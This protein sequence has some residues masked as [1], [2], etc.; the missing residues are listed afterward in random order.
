MRGTV[1][2]IMRKAAILTAHD[3]NYFDKKEYKRIKKLYRSFN[4][5]QNPKLPKK[6]RWDTSPIRRAKAPLYEGFRRRRQ[7]PVREIGDFYAD[8]SNI[9]KR[10]AFN[11][12][13]I[14]GYLPKPELTRR[15]EELRKYVEPRPETN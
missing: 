12:S 7:H 11:L 15:I 3:E 2:K 4:S 10:R 9:G 13:K 6:T 8:L 1:A 5:G 14:A